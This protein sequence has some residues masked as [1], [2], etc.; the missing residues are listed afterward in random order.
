MLPRPS[1]PSPI[2]LDPVQAALSRLPA[3]QPGLICPPTA[4]GAI[5]RSASSTASQ[6]PRTTA[7][8]DLDGL[9][10][11]QKQAETP[12]PAGQ[13]L[14]G[15]LLDDLALPPQVLA[16]TKRQ[17]STKYAAVLGPLALKALGPD[18][19][20]MT[21]PAMIEHEKMPILGV[22]APPPG[23]PPGAGAAIPPPM[24]MTQQPGMPA[25]TPAAAPVPD[26]TGSAPV[27][28]GQVPGQQA[29]AMAPSPAMAQPM[30]V[31]AGAAMPGAQ[32][33]AQPPQSGLSTAT[34]AA[35]LGNPNTL[36]PGAGTPAPS[37][38][39]TLAPPG[40]A[41][42]AAAAGGSGA[43]LAT[44]PQGSP[45]G[46]VAVGQTPIAGGPALAAPRNTPASNPINT[47]G[48]LSMS[49]E[50]N[51]NA[52]FGVA[53]S[54]M[55]GAS[56]LPD[57]GLAKTKLAAVLGMGE[58]GDP[59]ILRAK[60]R[61]ARTRDKLVSQYAGVPG[62]DLDGR[63]TALK[64]REKAWMDNYA[65][66]QA[67]L[68]PALA[69]MKVAASPGLFEQGGSMLGNALTS[70]KN[71]WNTSQG[72]YDTAASPIGIEAARAPVEKW[73]TGKSDA[74]AAQQPAS[75]KATVVRTNRAAERQAELA[76]LT[77]FPIVTTGSNQ[78]VSTGGANPT[79]ELQPG[80]IQYPTKHHV[81]VSND[82]PPQVGPGGVIQNQSR[83]T[84]LPK[85]IG[86]YQPLNPQNAQVREYSR[87]GIPKPTVAGILKGSALAE[88]LAVEQPRRSATGEGNIP[89]NEKPYCEYGADAMPEERYVRK[90]K[91]RVDS[92]LPPKYKP[93][94]G[95]RTTTG[96]N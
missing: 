71:W 7:Y 72:P 78:L 50:V 13:T 87:L 56:L 30:P 96:V 85:R 27:A 23:Q 82:H 79:M 83:Y 69:G 5:K 81:E 88:K 15:T 2:A 6:R 8:L 76:G 29:G 42:P 41:A 20:Q 70:A 55:K 73:M 49:G 45:A 32:P 11:S 54:T 75:F 62:F 14:T 12:L 57:H 47:Y 66:Q 19:P 25:P 9:T 24:G 48:A 59:Q 31:K 37:V 34:T 16:E 77:E 10:A 18:A 91:R 61:F 33:G 44:S 53:N 40:A 58:L 26:A 3:P 60:Q 68:Q 86:T 51:G 94:I 64:A 36:P 39:Q 17:L 46:G 63:I 43:A 65:A 89:Y 52:A 93:N 74:A 80:V 95:R 28:A 84:G 1:V 22:N 4:A 90:D 92:I 35:M 67:S 38:G 21:G